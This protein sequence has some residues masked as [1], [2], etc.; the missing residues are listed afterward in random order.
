MPVID[1]SAEYYFS[2]NWLSANIGIMGSSLLPAMERPWLGE[3]V[4][5]QKVVYGTCTR[6]DTAVGNCLSIRN[7]EHALQKRYIDIYLLLSVFI[8]DLRSTVRYVVDR[9]WNVISTN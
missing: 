6:V 2:A 1:I 4:R 7:I 3:L 5:R 8:F 9:I